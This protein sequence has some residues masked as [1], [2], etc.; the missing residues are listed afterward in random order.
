VGGIRDRSRCE[1]GFQPTPL[2]NCSNHAVWTPMTLSREARAFGFH[3]RYQGARWRRGCRAIVV[4]LIVVVVGLSWAHNAPTVAQFLIVVAIVAVVLALCEWLFARRM[5]LEIQLDGLVLRG[6]IRR[7]HAPWSQIQGFTWGEA[8]SLTKTE[9]IYVETDQAT[10][11][12]VPRDAPIRLPTIALVTRPFLPSDW[13]LGP[14]SL[15]AICD[16]RREKK[17]MRWRR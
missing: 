9:Y 4:F 2:P 12:R 8:R 6:P 3:G 1:T 10:P 5:G 7:I 15:L 13:F 14:Y 17:S 16:L 11:R